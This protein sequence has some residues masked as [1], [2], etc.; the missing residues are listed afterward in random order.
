MS[1]GP[2]PWDEARVAALR[3]HW[4]AGLSVAEIGGRLGL[5]K[6]AVVGKAH[7]L[8]LAPR[9][10]PIRRGIVAATSPGARSRRPGGAAAVEAAHIRA[11]A[12]VTIAALLVP[13][14]AAT[15]VPAPDPAPAM[16]RPV[17]RPRMHEPCCWPL[18]TPRT[19]GFRF[20]GAD[21]PPPPAT[22]AGLVGPA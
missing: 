18:G 9:P 10:S 17:A 1:D 22:S 6:N 15:S 14:P 12:S 20:C 19:P 11:G 8:G 7:R 4:D 2:A 21:A 3:A 5:T 16:M 13:P